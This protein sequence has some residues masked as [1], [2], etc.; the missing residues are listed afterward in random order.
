MA[1]PPLAILSALAQEQHGLLAQ[2]QN[3]HVRQRGGRSFAHG[4]LHGQDVVLALSRIGKVAAATTATTLIE[5]FGVQRIVFTG[6]AGALS[7]KLQVGDLLVASAFV[8]HDMDASPLF[9]RF[10]V[11]L[12]GRSQF[13]CDAALSLKLLEASKLAAE[14]LARTA[15]AAWPRRPQ[16]H[17]GLLASGDR[18]VG[19]AWESAAINQALASHNMCALAVEMEGAAVAQVCHDYGVAFAAVRTISDA[20]DD[21]AA[22]DFN[23]FLTQVAGRTTCA[24]VEHLLGAM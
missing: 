2:L 16:V 21:A 22:G 15:D 10:E 19:A 4:Q 12:Y 20:A 7:T 8:Q 11:P 6:V 3:G 9:T 18:F 5:A 13:A 24:V 17:Q 23:R 14:T 1:A